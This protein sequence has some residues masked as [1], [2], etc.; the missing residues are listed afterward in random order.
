MAEWT[1]NFMHPRYGTMF[2]TTIDGD[3]S[4]Q[5]MINNLISCGFIPPHH[6][7]YTLYNA[8]QAIAPD[9]LFDDITDLYD[10]CILRVA[11]NPEADNAAPVMPTDTSISLQ[12]LH[13]LQGW[14]TRIETQPEQTP[15][16]LLQQL[17][18]RGFLVGDIANYALQYKGNILD[19]NKSFK[20][21]ALQ[22]SDF[23]EI[24]DL[25][26]QTASPLELQIQQIQQELALQQQ[27]TQQQLQ[28]ILKGLPRP[29]SLPIDSVIAINPT[30]ARY[31][32]FDSIVH[33]IR[34]IDKLPAI[35]KV[36]ARSIVPWLLV[37]SLL[38]LAT[39]MGIFWHKIMELF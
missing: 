11:P 21:T 37:F 29:S 3:F 30:E 14:T 18:Q 27:Q 34:Q 9:A 23:V 36:Y 4:A 1:L 5:E 22:S 33:N 35:K 38:V 31:E 15:L 20:E 12:I 39:A 26:K 10:G 2:P 16:Q 32:S 6:T 25:Q 19:I 13:P 7:G 28:N 17:L 24:I 8:D